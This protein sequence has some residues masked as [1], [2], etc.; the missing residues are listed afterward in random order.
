MDWEEHQARLG[1]LVTGFWL[2]LF[3]L[4]FGH[5]F[6]E[7]KFFLFAGLWLGAVLAVVAMLSCLIRLSERRK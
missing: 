6:R 7:P 1:W 4:F 3:W 2:G 5:G